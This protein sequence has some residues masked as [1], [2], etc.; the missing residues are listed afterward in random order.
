MVVIGDKNLKELVGKVVSD[1]MS[2]TLVIEVEA[3]KV[4]RLYHKRSVK[5][6]KYYAHDELEVAGI[7]DI[8]RIREDRPR[9]KLKRWMFLEVIQKAEG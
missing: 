5:A 9:S 2:K 4:N 1:R 3:V 8:V 7:G 6:K